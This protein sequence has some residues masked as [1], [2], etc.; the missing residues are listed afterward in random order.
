MLART[1]LHWKVGAVIVAVLVFSVFLAYGVVGEDV[2]DEVFEDVPDEI[3]EGIMEE[4]EEVYVPLEE[5]EEESVEEL[6]SEELYVD[7]EEVVEEEVAEEEAEEESDE[8]YVDI[9]EL[10]D[11]VVEADEEIEE[12]VYLDLEEVEEAAQEPEVIVDSVGGGSRGSSGVKD[13]E[14]VADEI[15]EEV[16]EDELLDEEVVQEEGLE[17]EL[18]EAVRLD[19]LVEVAGEVERKE[20]MKVLYSDDQSEVVEDIKRNEEVI[21]ES[22]EMVKKEAVVSSGDEHFYGDIIYSSYLDVEVESEEQITVNWKTE[23]EEMEFDVFDENDNGLIDKISWV[24]PHLSVQEFE[25]VI[26]FNFEENETLTEIGIERVV[27]P[28]GERQSPVE[29]EFD[30]SYYNVSLVLCNLSLS[31]FDG[32]FS[33]EFREGDEYN[34]SFVLENGDYSWDLYCFDE[35]N[36]SINAGDDGEFSINADYVPVVTLAADNV[37]ILEGDSVSFDISVSVPE[38]SDVDSITYILSYGDGEEDISLPY[39]D[40]FEFNDTLTHTYESSDTYSVV[41]TGI[42]RYDDDLEYSNTY[43]LPITV[44]AAPPEGDTE[45]PTIRMIE[46][47]DEEHFYFESTDQ[48]IKLSYNVTDDVKIDNCTLEIYYWDDS[49]G[50]IVYERFKDDITQGDKISVELHDFDEGEH[51]WYVKCFDNSSKERERERDFYVYYDE[52]GGGSRGSSGSDDDDE[53]LSDEDAESVDEISE[54]IDSINDFLIGEEKYD[55]DEKEAVEDLGIVD[56]MKLYKKKML[57]NKQDLQHNLDYVRDEARRE[58]RRDAIVDEIEQM[59]KEI[60]VSF[61]VVDSYE[62]FKNSLEFDMEEVVQAYV[63]SRGMVLN[64]GGIRSMAKE[65]EAIQNK[66]TVSVRTKHVEMKYFD[67]GKEEITL[68]T[69]EIDFKDRSFDSLLE[70]IPKSVAEDAGDVSFV[71]V[72]TRVVKADPIFEIELEDFEED[73]IVYYVDGF[74]DLTGFEGTTTLAFKE[75]IPE[76]RLGGITGFV[77]FVSGEGNGIGFYLSWILVLAAVAVIG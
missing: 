72:E 54:L 32:G 44:D 4:S 25:I 70:V 48:E 39:Y 68:V 66:I 24:I 23:G 22:E 19:D 75:E 18:T 71:D 41:L 29:F 35:T 43:N 14:E 77:S 5:I 49:F 47:D 34:Q 74:I 36:G 31:G 45:P 7:L 28:E 12:P 59:R 38:T 15:G 53:S 1:K 67:G 6:E 60:P 20:V 73:R 16:V 11:E 76:S 2:V 9:D 10:I 50:E 69:K 55:I 8:I 57:Q 26:V 61:E 63:D 37:S 17:E 51:T 21:E 42:A 65:N 30:I 46:P 58:E 62:Y 56:K 3:V 13:V 33:E 27:V 64:Q 52:D 40:G